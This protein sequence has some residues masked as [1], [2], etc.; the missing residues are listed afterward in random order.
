M[1]VMKTTSI[2]A[3]SRVAVQIKEQWYTVEYEEV[4]TLPDNNTIPLTDNELDA[5]REDLWNTVNSQVDKQVDEILSAFN[6]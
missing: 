1:S 3:T 6:K 2:K 5:E 4:R